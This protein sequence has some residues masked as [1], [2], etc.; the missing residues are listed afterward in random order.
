MRKSLR[1]AHMI[2]DPKD[3]LRKVVRQSLMLAAGLTVFLFFILSKA[4]GPAI[5]ILIFP[6]CFVLSFVFFSNEPLVQIR[7]R[8]KEID[9]EILF[10]TRFMILKIESGVPLFNAF[11]DA[12]DSYGVAGKYFKEIVD[13]INLGKPIEKA[14]EEAREYSASLSFK[15]IMNQIVTALKT[16]AHVSTALSAA[17]EEIMRQQQI[18][19]QAYGKKMNAIIMFYLMMAV[20]VPSLGVAMLIVLSG[21][22]NLAVSMPILYGIVLFI[23][24]IQFSFIF[25]IRSIRPAIEL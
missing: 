23:A 17:I 8:A 5:I 12:S 2:V 7:R 19:I 6:L 22:L 21:F 1:M 4:T 9:S 15:A 11:I 25:I 3:F 16:G 18:Q 13:E 10:A 20:V 24:L 14:V